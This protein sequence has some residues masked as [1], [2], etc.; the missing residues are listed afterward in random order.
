MAEVPVIQ[1]LNKKDYFKQALVPIP[2]PLPPLGESSLR[3][4]TDVLALT[5]NNFT[6][7]KLADLADWWGIHRI[8]PTTPAPYNDTSVYGR[9][10]AW[11][12]AKVVDSTFPSVPKGRYVWGYLPIGTLPQDFQ[13]KE[14]GLPGQF[15]VTEPYRKNHLKLYNHYFVCPEGIEHAI[16]GKADVIAYGALFRVMHLTAWIMAEFMFSPDPKQSVNL[17]PEQADLTDATV[18]SFAPGSKVGLAFAHALRQRTAS[19]PARI[20]GAASEHSQA[21]VKGTGFYDAVEPT[22]ADPVEVASRLGVSKKDG[23]IVIVDF[24]GRNHVQW[25][26]AEALVSAYPRVQF[27][28]VGAEVS[29]PSAAIAPGGKPPAGLDIAQVMADTQQ[30]QAIEKVGEVEY[31]TRNDAAWDTFWKAGIPGV[32]LVWGEGMEAVKDAWDRFARGE[33]SSEEALVFK[34]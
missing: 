6:Y 3:I 12:F 1:V 24:G 5:S 8:P 30:N 9:I 7:C 31:W 33:V 20:V 27:V 14:A 32:K 23:K 18:I 28:S 13:V 2:D 11:G 25:K 22:S 19:K 4:R 29:E 10:S 34:V 21:F 16:A 17:T 15:F 26:W